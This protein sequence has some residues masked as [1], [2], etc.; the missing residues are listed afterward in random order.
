MTMYAIIEEGGGQRKVTKDDVI[1]ID[2]VEGGA[3]APGQ[4]VTFD[5]VLA[6]GQGDGKAVA[7]IGQPFVAG[8]KVTGEVVESFV[9]GDKLLIQKFRRRKGYRRRTGHRQ[10]YTRVKIT[11]IVGA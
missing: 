7:K 5:R 8:A 9:K 2:L 10:K 6:I 11:E 4:K 3:S 1:L